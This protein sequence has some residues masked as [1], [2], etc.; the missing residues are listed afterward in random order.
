MI[1]WIPTYILRKLNVHE[2]HFRIKGE[3]K[4]TNDILTQAKFL[5]GSIDKHKAI[6]RNIAFAPTYV[7]AKFVKVDHYDSRVD[8]PEELVQP[9]YDMLYAYYD[10]KLKELEKEFEEL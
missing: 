4:M 3:V 9:I 1:F 7:D 2:K 10:R 5:S 6:L 8:I